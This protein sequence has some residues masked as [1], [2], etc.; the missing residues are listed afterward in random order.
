MHITCVNH[1][2]GSFF[3]KDDLKLVYLAQLTSL[4]GI[5]CTGTMGTLLQR[6][7]PSRPESATREQLQLQLSRNM[8]VWPQGRQLAQDYREDPRAY[9]QAQM[10]QSIRAAQ[11]QNEAT[12]SKQAQMQERMNINSVFL[13][14]NRHLPSDISRQ[15]AHIYKN[16]STAAKIQFAHQLAQ[17][18]SRAN[19]TAQSLEP[20]NMS[21]FVD[22]RSS[23][24]QQ[25]QQHLSRV[26]YAE[27]PSIP[28]GPSLDKPAAV[29]PTGQVGQAYGYS[30]EQPGAI[31]LK[32][33]AQITPTLKK[34]K[35]EYLPLIPWRITITQAASILPTMG[36]VL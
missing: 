14:A 19:P 13:S 32:Q 12:T 29:A 36:C 33:P 26:G 24:Q 9:A 4:H 27:R 34:R 17:Q 18:S 20:S 25:L 21:S 11:L 6:P 8:E 7:T 22:P 16:L 2:Q 5:C 3:S 35:K 30:Q 28:A 10:A 15:A 1:L 23:A 31:Q